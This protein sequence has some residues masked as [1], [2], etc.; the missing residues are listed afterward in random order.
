MNGKTGSLR[1]QP[2]SVKDGVVT[3]NGQ[4]G[5]FI[6]AD[7]PYYRDP[8]E[9]W[10][11]RLQKLSGLGLQ[12]VT[13]YIPWR[14]HQ[15]DPQMQPDFTGKTQPNRNVV[16]FLELCRELSLS[17]IAKPGPFIHA[18]VNY[19]GLPDWTCPLNNPEIEA[20]LDAQGQTV[21]WSGGR[22]EAASQRIEQWPLPAPFDHE[23]LRLTEAW[24]RTVAVQVIHP[25]SAPQ[26]PI[27]GLQIANEGL[28]SNGQH[29][30]WAYDYSAAS[31]QR[32]H[33]FL[34]SNYPDLAAYNRLNHTNHH[35][36]EAIQPPRAWKKPSSPE[37]L[38]LYSDWG[39]YL[40]EY[41][42][43]VYRAWTAPLQ[44]DL[45]VFINQNPPLGEAYGLDA[46][47]TRVEP[48][49]WPGVTYGFTNW[50][51][52]ISARPSA[53]DRYLL[54]AKWHPGINLE[55]NWGFAELYDPAY[56]DAAT[57]FYQ[58]LA[59][60]NA[61]ATGFNIYTGVGTSFPDRNLE[62]LPK[63]P[64]P[65]AAPITHT[66][67][68]TPKAH[69]AAWLVEFFR[70]YGQDF[71]ESQP[72]RTA[73]FGV[74]LPL[75]R[76]AAWAH[77][78]VEQA[79][80]LLNDV[81]QADT[82]FEPA[83]GTHLARFQSEM[84]RLHLDYGV[85]NLEA[86]SLEE[87]L[88]YRYLL[89]AGS[90]S[91]SQAV[92]D[93]LLS[94]AKSGGKLG[95]LGVIPTLDEHFQAC[96]TLASQKDLFDTMPEMDLEYWLADAPRPRLVSGEADIWL[97]SSKAGDLHLLTVLIP[98]GAPPHV[99]LE[100]SLAGQP[101]RLSLDAAPSGG[102]L[103]CV[104]DR[105]VTAAILKGHNGFLGVSVPPRLVFDGQE[106]GMAEPGDM[107]F[108]PGSTRLIKS[109]EYEKDAAK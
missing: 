99:E 79:V 106:I 76:A 58:T 20:L 98:A 27:V 73:A 33:S 92:Q 65:D 62:V 5:V 78:H 36:W 109:G 60:L 102:A 10:R 18:E 77:T 52:D 22:L 39:A 50:V 38:R 29:A 75:A 67:E 68:V 48:Q 11:D 94:Y 43:A 41:I 83:L 47:L 82:L 105:R 84:R 91:M 24:L 23:F 19:G 17:V 96:D 46:W 16:H 74:Y 69:I 6:S 72:E 71:L 89:V 107:A 31:V 8:M 37:A 56:I 85:L 108:F 26:G 95:L 4:A 2:L 7:Y 9:A 45:P 1:Y 86:A 101:C 42:G 104:Q 97:R 57:C 51:G 88:E 53:F 49:R 80:S 32:F 25:F 13:I 54:T 70:L 34:K 30:P 63:A 103:L 28:Y 93:K 15:P 35:S 64:Y 3:L 61:G 81:E 87:L 66:G 44:S 12:V 40:A 21:D 55:E 59:V 14:H 90:P 100:I